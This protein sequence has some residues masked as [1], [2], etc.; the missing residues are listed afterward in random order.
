MA[1]RSRRSKRRAKAKARDEAARMVAAAGEHRAGGDGD[2]DDGYGLYY[3]TRSRCDPL[4][5]LVTSME[6]MS[7][8]DGAAA[9][10]KF[11]D[12]GNDD[13]TDTTDKF[14]F[15][16]R[17]KGKGN[18]TTDKFNDRCKGEGFADDDNSK[19]DD[20]NDKDNNTQTPHKI[21]MQFGS[22]TLVLHDDGSGDFTENVKM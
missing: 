9:G 10:Y 4:G 19:Y 5:S 11:T 1:S 21:T 7:I 16:D 6:S 18:D 14:T 22:M 3:R 8:S 12:R 20:D 15:T 13:G 2:D 17:G